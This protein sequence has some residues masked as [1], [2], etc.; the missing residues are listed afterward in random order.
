[1]KDNINLNTHKIFNVEAIYY[2]KCCR[3]ISNNNI[4]NQH[5]NLT[6]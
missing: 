4:S 3:I 5:L 1:M 6:S 2:L